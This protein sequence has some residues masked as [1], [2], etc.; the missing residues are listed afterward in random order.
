M[1]RSLQA[2]TGFALWGEV[3]EP[4]PHA[5]TVFIFDYLCEKLADQVPHHHCIRL[6]Y[7]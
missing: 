5:S 4:A 6:I 2:V 7:Q 3:K 1:R